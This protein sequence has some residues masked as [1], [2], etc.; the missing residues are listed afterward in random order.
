MEQ[1]GCLASLLQSLE[2]NAT[3]NGEGRAPHPAVKVLG[4]AVPVLQRVM[5]DADLQADATVF[6]AL[7]EVSLY[8]C[9]L[10]HWIVIKH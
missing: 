1:L 8:A 10:A 4:R 6:C 5:Q 7:C 9:L 3:E 2:G